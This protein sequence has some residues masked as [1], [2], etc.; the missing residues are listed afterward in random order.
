LPWK[1]FY[2]D[3][4]ATPPD[5]KCVYKRKGHKNPYLSWYAQF[6]EAMTSTDPDMDYLKPDATV[7]LK[8]ERHILRPS[9][10]LYISTPY[11]FAWD[12]LFPEESEIV[13]PLPYRLDIPGL[14]SFIRDFDNMS[15]LEIRA[16]SYRPKK[17]QPPKIPRDTLV[18]VA[19]EKRELRIKERAEGKKISLNDPRLRFTAAEDAFI[20]RNYRPKMTQETKDSIM[21]ACPGH[22]WEVIGVRAK[23]LCKNLIE[24]GVTDLNQLP[25]VYATSRMKKFLSKEGV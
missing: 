12:S 4:K 8:A 23:I 7:D 15:E 16:R 6:F 11:L 10:Q 25:H 5:P 18:V 14:K 21:N 1:E 22:S 20:C 24:L 19:K 9:V 3:Y 13:Y 17:A 2:R